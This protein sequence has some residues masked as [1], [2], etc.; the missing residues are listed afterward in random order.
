VPTP[1]RSRLGRYLRYARRR[2]GFGQR[3][4]AELIGCSVRTVQRAEAGQTWPADEVVCEWERATG[5]EILA[6]SPGVP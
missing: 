5:F 2:A 6:D 4:L 1:I 3:E